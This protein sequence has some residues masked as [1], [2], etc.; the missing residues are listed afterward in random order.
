LL[1][2]GRE[3]VAQDSVAVAKKVSFVIRYRPFIVWNGI[4][5]G[6][7]LNPN[8]SVEIYGTG[9]ATIELLDAQ[10]VLEHSLIPE[11]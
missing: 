3:G 6:Y 1:G 2:V 8:N 4:G 11:L 5:V 10:L 9:Q 7:F